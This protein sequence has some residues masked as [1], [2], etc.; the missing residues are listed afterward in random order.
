[1]NDSPY[2]QREMELLLKGIDTKIDGLRK[3][4]QTSTSQTKDRFTQV[5]EEIKEIRTE[6]AAFRVDLSALKDFQTKAMAV[7]GVVAAVSAT[8]F[9]A[10]LNKFL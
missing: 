2:T 1:M 4:I 10:I 6:Q 8:V 9:A 7:W 5:D 3:D